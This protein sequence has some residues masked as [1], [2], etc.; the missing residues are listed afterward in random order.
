[1][2]DKELEL[3]GRIIAVIDEFTYDTFLDYEIRKRVAERLF[4]CSNLFFEIKK[5]KEQ[6]STD[7]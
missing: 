3:I 6:S 7:K 4:I 5:S 1:M 2:N